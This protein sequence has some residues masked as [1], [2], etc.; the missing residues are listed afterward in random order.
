MLFYPNLQTARYNT[1][2][3]LV[4]WSIVPDKIY[5]SMNIITYRN[6]LAGTGKNDLPNVRAHLLVHKFCLTFVVL[7]QSSD[8]NVCVTLSLVLLIGVLCGTKFMIQWI[9]LSYRK[10]LAGTG[11]NDLPNV[12]THFLVHKFC[13]IVVVLPQSSDCKA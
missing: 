11:K 12:R 9:W 10:L 4:D 3:G 8:C 7:R 1:F 13:L 5:D 2:A 6:L